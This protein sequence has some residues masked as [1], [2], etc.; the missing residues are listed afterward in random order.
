MPTPWAFYFRRLL[1]RTGPFD[2]MGKFHLAKSSAQFNGPSGQSALS[3]D[4]ELAF[5]GDALECLG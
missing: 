4:G 3:G 5:L 1:L 2:G